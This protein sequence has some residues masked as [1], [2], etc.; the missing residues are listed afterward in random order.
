MRCMGQIR[1]N[2]LGIISPV[3]HSCF[4]AIAG[5]V[6]NDASFAN[7]SHVLFR[8]KPDDNNDDDIQIFGDHSRYIS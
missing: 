3:V 1:V 7:M 2:I 4:N 8:R 6:Q 5:F